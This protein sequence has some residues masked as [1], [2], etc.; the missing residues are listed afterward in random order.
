MNKDFTLAN[1][2]RSADVMKFATLGV[3][4]LGSAQRQRRFSLFSKFARDR[5][6]ATIVATD[7]NAGIDTEDWLLDG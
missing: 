6:E 1:M 3:R 7:L 5:I 2:R 4:L